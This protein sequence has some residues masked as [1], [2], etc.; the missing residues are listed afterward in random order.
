VVHGGGLYGDKPAAMDRFVRRYHDLKQV[1]RRRLVL[2][3]DERTYTL[4]DTHAIHQ[5]T[6]IR[7]VFDHL[8]Y[9]CHPTPGMTPD[10][11]LRLALGTWP[12]GQTPKIHYSTTRTSINVIDRRDPSGSRVR[13]LR[14]PR[15]SQ[16]A[17]LID[18]FAFINLLRDTRSERGFD[19][20]LECKAKDL[21]LLR[22][23]KHLNRYVPD[24][25]AHHH[26]T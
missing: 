12:E 20:M 25:V 1:T 10:Q 15:I 6:G 19:V 13:H 18:P 8:H 14:E 21:A 3:N 11:A 5:R 4:G 2:E 24:L 16:H 26:I 7:L 17:D 9:C 22:L 23:R